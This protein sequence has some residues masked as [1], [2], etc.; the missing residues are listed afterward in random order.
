MIDV[1]PWMGVAATIIRVVESL[2]TVLLQQLLAIF[3]AARPVRER[4]VRRD[5]ATLRQDPMRLGEF[6]IPHRDAPYGSFALAMA[7]DH[8]RDVAVSRELTF[9]HQACGAQDGPTLAVPWQ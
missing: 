2:Y 5:Q 3:W 6:G 7:I 1:V 9:A 8:L 4:P